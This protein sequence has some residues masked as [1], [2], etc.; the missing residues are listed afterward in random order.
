MKINY[1]YSYLLVFFSFQTAFSQSSPDSLRNPNY[2]KNQIFYQQSYSFIA[3]HKN[4]VQ[5]SQANTV[6]HFFEKLSKSPTQQ[7][8]V[9][10]IG[11]SHVQFDVVSGTVRSRFQKIFGQGGR[12]LVFPI[13]ITH[14]NPPIDYKSSHWGSWSYSKNV[15]RNQNHDLG[16]TGITARTHD[17][18]A[19]FRLHFADNAIKANFLKIKVLAKH[20]E[21]SFSLKLRFS[22]N[23]APLMLHFDDN[24][25]GF[26]EV[27]L[28][29]ASQ[30]LDFEIVKDNAH[31]EFF[32]LYGII[33]ENDTQNG[34][35]YSSTGIN[36]AG[37][38][39]VVTQKLL[40][41]QIGDYQ[42][43]LIILDLGTNDFRSGK[44]YPDQIRHY[45]TKIIDSIRVYAPQSTILLTTTQDFFKNRR[46]V[47]ECKIYSQLIKELANEKQCAFYDFYE[48]G[49]G[50][51]SMLHWQRNELAQRDLLH[52]SI[53]GYRTKGELY[54]NAL[55]NSYATYLENPT[56]SLLLEQQKDT[57]LPQL[58]IKEELK[59]EKVKVARLS[60]AA[61][62][63]PI[64]EKNK[65][66]KITYVIKNG[67]NLGVLAEK[68]HVTTKELKTWNS[69]ENDR[70]F[71]GDKLVIY[72]DKS[73]APQIVQKVNY[74]KTSTHT[75][76]KNDSLWKIAKRHKVSVE[77]IKKLNKLSS[78]KLQV[79]QELRVK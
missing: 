29:V 52:L 24:S 73:K 55:L 5:W 69:L 6:S 36:G 61:P 65:L 59:E 37:Y 22:D 42:P 64:K 27:L 7:V 63:S 66:G 67:D 70:I 39:H 56:Q 20:S 35:L 72:L 78:E 19:G 4:F 41:S 44:I 15:N 31:Q 74:K 62:S 45:A 75:V 26:Q 33:I 79:G 14:T 48:I 38:H 43:D 34:I 23:Q 18:R 12:G 54:A 57:I 49:G 60:S 9:L 8:K 47:L 71:Y 32:E 51:G 10:H 46:S 1:L 17:S 53:K 2:I 13:S 68:F 11:D 16:M 76:R 3:Y 40:A 30:D 21:K 28:P 25:K 58:V 77:Q 50:Q